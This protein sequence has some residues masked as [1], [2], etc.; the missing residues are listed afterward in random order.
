MK[1]IQNYKERFFNLMESKMGDV[2]P[3]TEKRENVQE[4]APVVAG[5][6][7]LG[8]GYALGTAIYSLVGRNKS[9][10]LSIA[11]QECAKKRI[12]PTTSSNTIAK[13]I[14]NG[15]VDIGI[16]TNEELVYSQF[17]SIKT[18]QQFCEVAASYQQMYGET[19][20][21]GIDGDFDGN[22]LNFFNEKI[23][24]LSARDYQREKAAKNPVQPTTTSLPS[25]SGTAKTR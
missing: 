11:V 10:A 2:K 24:D 14:Y 20:W 21:D 23:V 6:A 15:L 1:N 18:T 3:I 13:A 7:V 22:S 19:L 16:G 5:A 17:N 9:N 12:R 8:A 4:L 25:T